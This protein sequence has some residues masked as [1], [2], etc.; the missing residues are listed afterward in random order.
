[1]SWRHSTGLGAPAGRQGEP[2]CKRK[3]TEEGRKGRSSGG[4]G[5]PAEP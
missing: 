2:G 4:A 3:D 5:L 1:M